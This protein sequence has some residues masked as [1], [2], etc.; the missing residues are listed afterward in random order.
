MWK[1]KDANNLNNASAIIKNGRTGA[2]LVVKLLSS[3][4]L[5]LKVVLLEKT[6]GAKEEG[7]TDAKEKVKK[8]R[9]E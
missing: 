5:P 6:M 7:K 9:G 2:M 1:E 3:L 8:M 4:M